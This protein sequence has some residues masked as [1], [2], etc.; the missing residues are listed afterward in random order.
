MSVKTS[1]VSYFYLDGRLHKNIKASRSND[2][3]VAYDYT[4]KKM[5]VYPLSEVMR[6]KQN[7]YTL[8]QVANMLG[9]TPKTL[10]EYFWAGEFPFM[11]QRSHP[12]GKPDARYTWRFSEDHVL[13]IRD[14][15]ASNKHRGRPRSDGLVVSAALPSREELRTLMR[16]NEVMYI[17]EGDKFVPVWTA[18]RW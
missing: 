7:C 1:R 17:K 5:K 6:K 9:R 12:V 2:R 18:D 15:L 10:R 3:L 8:P 4:D 13:Q 11:P 16:T 14:Y